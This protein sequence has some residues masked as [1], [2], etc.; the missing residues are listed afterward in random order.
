MERVL[1][2]HKYPKILDLQIGKQ[3]HLVV[4]DDLIKVS[5]LQHRLILY[6]ADGK[7]KTLYINFKEFAERLA[8]DS[9]FVCCT[10]GILVNLAFIDFID[11]SDFVM[12][13]GNRVP[14]SRSKLLEMR[15]ALFNFMILT[16]REGGV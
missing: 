11:K 10:R 12:K 6:M 4:L 15:N 8:K 2:L 1:A 9:T 14:I 13:N 5:S 7:D 3:K 16:T